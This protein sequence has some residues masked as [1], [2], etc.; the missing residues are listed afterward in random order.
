MN[1]N[2]FLLLLLS[3]LFTLPNLGLT[4]QMSWVKCLQGEQQ[5][6][7]QNTR[8]IHKGGP[9]RMCG[10]HT[11]M[12]TAGDNTGQNTNKG[13][14]PKSR[15][16]IK[17][18]DLVGNRIRAAWLEGRDSTNHHEQVHFRDNN[19]NNNKCFGIIRYVDMH[20]ERSGMTELGPNVFGNYFC[21]C[22]MDSCRRPV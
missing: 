6:V 18:P 3:L 15:T 13:H 16:E 19:N 5:S 8:Q 4:T 2:K 1:F 7:D 12:A 11:V 22:C 9:P 20:G 10:K 14:A 17:I 21:T